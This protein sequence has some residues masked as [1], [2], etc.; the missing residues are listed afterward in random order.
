MNRPAVEDPDAMQ[1]LFTT[2]IQHVEDTVS[3]QDRYIEIFDG[4][5]VR[6]VTTRR[7]KRREAE[8][9]NEAKENEETA[10]TVENE[11]T[12][13]ADDRIT[14]LMLEENVKTAL[15]PTTPDETEGYVH[16]YSSKEMREGQNE[17]DDLTLIL[18]YLRTKEP[19][20]SDVLALSSPAAKKY[21]VNRE[22]FYLSQDDIL[23]NISKKNVHRMVVPARYKEEVTRL[24]HD[25]ICTGHQ[26]IQRTR[27][28][29]GGKYYWYNMNDYIQEYVQSCD[30]CSRFKKASRKAKAPMTKFHAGAPMERV[31]LDFLGPLPETK[32]GN[33]NILVMVDQFTKWCEII[34]LPSQTAEVTARSAVNDFFARFGCPFTIHT[35]QGRNFESKLFQSICTLLKIHKTRTTPIDHQRTARWNDLTER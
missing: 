10:G 4:R 5:H 16:S 35:D 15:P 22:C 1:Q 8:I 24:N 3:D 2:D 6:L 20:A 31:H 12:Q 32:R 33:I 14:E 7:S 27:E 29:I 26:G 11:E 18:G 28:R 17:D 30:K 21:W 25:L 23:Y 34:P 13:M 19:P 9:A